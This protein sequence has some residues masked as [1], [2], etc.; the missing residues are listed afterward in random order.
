MSLDIDHKE[1][2]KALN[3]LIKLQKE[4]DRREKIILMV[5]VVG[6]VISVF[7]LVIRFS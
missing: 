6:L 7:S 2:M 4:S 3:E 5:S 1:K